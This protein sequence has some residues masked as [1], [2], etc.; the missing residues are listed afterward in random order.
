V[1]DAIEQPEPVRMPSE[2][3]GTHISLEV[4]TLWTVIDGQRVADGNF[5][6]LHLNSERIALTREGALE[7]ADGIAEL[8]T[9]L[10][11]TGAAS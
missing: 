10:P 2:Q 4:G 3:Q 8:A 1:S 9:Q 6:M 11:P 7:L 5:V